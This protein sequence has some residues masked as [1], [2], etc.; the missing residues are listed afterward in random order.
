MALHVYRY[1][2]LVFLEKILFRI[3]VT[4]SLGKLFWVVE[5]DSEFHYYRHNFSHL[6]HK[7]YN[8]VDVGKTIFF[9]QNLN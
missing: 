2:S 1:K 3:P 5:R 7:S 8:K 4:G 9:K 6:I